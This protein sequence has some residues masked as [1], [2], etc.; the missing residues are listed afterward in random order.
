MGHR[1]RE[2][3]AETINDLGDFKCVGGGDPDLL[4]LQIHGI[5]QQRLTIL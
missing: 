1:A 2:E 5:S 3:K 4:H